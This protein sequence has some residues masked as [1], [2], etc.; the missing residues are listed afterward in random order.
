MRFFLNTNFIIERN[1]CI[2][3]NEY[4]KD[5]IGNVKNPGLIY[6]KVL[7]GQGYFED[8]LLKIKKS[9]P[10][11]EIKINEKEGEP[12]YQYLNEL[13]NYFRKKNIDSIIAI[14]GGSTMD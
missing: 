3:I 13:S 10:S 7:N 8:I 1:A 12:T 4:I 2:K 14:G 5:N 9:F 11:L 6:D